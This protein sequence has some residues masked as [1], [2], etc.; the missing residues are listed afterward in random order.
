LTTVRSNFHKIME[1]L[2]PP[3]EELTGLSMV[4]SLFP[5]AC[6]NW[7]MDHFELWVFNPHPEH[8]NRSCVVNCTL[9]IPGREGTESETRHWENT[10]NVL[11]ASVVSEDFEAMK[12]IQKNIESGMVD[13]FTFGRN[14]MALQCFH[15]DLARLVTENMVNSREKSTA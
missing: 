2:K 5:N 12:E 11:T 4:Y 9:L 8:N 3:F 13:T 14:E 15:R 6:L 10:W 1:N 7:V